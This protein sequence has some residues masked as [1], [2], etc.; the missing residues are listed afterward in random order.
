MRC[1]EESDASIR[2]AVLSGD[3]DAYR[4]LVARYTGIV[5]G[6]LGGRQW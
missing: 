3:K 6:F 1:M 4:L 5:I 2:R